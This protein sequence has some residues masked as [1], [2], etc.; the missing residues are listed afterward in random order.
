MLFN[1]YIFILLFLPVTWVIY[2]GLNKLNFSRMANVSL[3][4][5]SL[6][7]YGFNNWK[8]A[9]ILV[10]SIIVNYLLHIGFFRVEKGRKILLISG[11]VY[12]FGILFYFKYFIFI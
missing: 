6:V 5:A 8:F 1:S 2:F 12:N 10:A 3:V 11:L 9:L 4:L 7:F